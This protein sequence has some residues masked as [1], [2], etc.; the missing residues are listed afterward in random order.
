MAP[1]YRSHTAF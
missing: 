1:F